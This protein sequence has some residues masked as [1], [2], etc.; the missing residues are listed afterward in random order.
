MNIVKTMR[1][2]NEP[3]LYT[4][5]SS[6]TGLSMS[7]HASYKGQS[8]IIGLNSIFFLIYSFCVTDWVMNS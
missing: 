7:R 6:P 1:G 4:E 8:C 5:R 2:S 3:H